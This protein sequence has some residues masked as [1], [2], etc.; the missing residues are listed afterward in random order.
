MVDLL[1]YP[2]SMGSSGLCLLK[3]E[4][5][6]RGLDIKLIKK[7]NSSYK[8][9]KNN[10]V[11]N[12]GNGR[13][14]VWG[15]KV[16]RF[17]NDP[18]RINGATNKYRFFNIIGKQLPDNIPEFTTSMSEASKWAKKDVV[19]CRKV[20]C[21]KQGKGIVIADMP[22]KVVKAPLYTKGVDTDIEYRVHVFD[23]KVIDVVRKFYFG[24]NPDS[25]I[26]NLD[27]GWAFIRRGINLT[28]QLEKLSIKVCNLLALDFCALDV[29]VANNK[30]IFLEANT[31]PGMT[32]I[33]V[34]KY[35]NVIEKLV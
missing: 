1:F 28:P 15:S 10:I 32:G 34:I 30:Y 29:L 35:A 11:I 26:R 25:L 19:F 33:T 8:G 23:N 5:E 21:G 2:Y 12:W 6:S 27:N 3:E 18:L 16:R 17:Y 24:S 13:S 20:L 4:L 31:A 7:K 22:S 9:N 14:A